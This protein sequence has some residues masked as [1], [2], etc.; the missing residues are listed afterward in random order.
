MEVVEFGV[1]LWWES[2]S[3]RTEADVLAVD[4]PICTGTK[5]KR[6]SR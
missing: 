6:G 5:V 4:L 3:V 2:D 1:R